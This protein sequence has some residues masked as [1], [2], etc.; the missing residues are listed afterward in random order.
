[1]SAGVGR[2]RVGNMLHKMDGG[3]ESGVKM[4]PPRLRVIVCESDNENIYISMLKSSTL[5]I[6]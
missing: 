3:K 5:C 4:N 2:V 1:M 6:L